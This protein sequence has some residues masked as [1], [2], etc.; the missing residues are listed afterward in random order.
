MTEELASKLFFYFFV[1][2]SKFLPKQIVR[3]TELTFIFLILDFKK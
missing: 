3:P 2:W 1:N